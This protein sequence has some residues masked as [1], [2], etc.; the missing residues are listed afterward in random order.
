MG[1]LQP[2]RLGFEG[3]VLIME[4]DIITIIDIGARCFVMIAIVS[5]MV[6]FITMNVKYRDKK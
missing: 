3:T 5:G 6:G 2:N 1:K 4:Y